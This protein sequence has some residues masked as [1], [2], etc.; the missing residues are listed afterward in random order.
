[1]EDLNSNPEL[2]SAPNGNNDHENNSTTDTSDALNQNEKNSQSVTC[3][4][5]RST[6]LMPDVAIKKRL[7]HFLPMMLQK[8]FNNSEELEGENLEEFWMVEDM[9]HFENVGFSKA[10][11]NIKYLICADCE[12]GPIGFHDPATPKEFYIALARI[13]HCD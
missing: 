5:C 10:V 13:N 8:K 6:V 12:M 9:Y 1:M 2:S 3:K 11:N 7:D 4:H